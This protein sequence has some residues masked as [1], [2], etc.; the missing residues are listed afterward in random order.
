MVHMV[1]VVNIVCT[2]YK[3][4]S[5]SVPQSIDIRA[6]GRLSTTIVTR[7]DASITGDEL[8]SAVQLSNF[9]LLVAW[10]TAC[11][12]LYIAQG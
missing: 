11:M 6:Q 7:F 8:N 5:M 12:M 4:T 1:K 2:I 3:P 10:H 9:R